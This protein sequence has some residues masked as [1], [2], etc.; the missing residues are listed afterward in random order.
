MGARAIG[1]VAISFGMVTIPVKLYT[2]A[3]SASQIRF[4]QLEQATGARVKQQYISSKTGEIVPR[5]DMV[6]GYEFSK[7]Q[8]V[9]FTPDELKAIEAKSNHAIEINEFVPAKDVDPL[10][11]DKSYYIGPDKGGARAYHLLREAMTQT[12]RVA[13]ASYASRG[14]GYLVMVRPFEHGLIM[15]QLRYSDEVRAFAE[16][17][18]EEVEIRKDELK[19]AIQLIEQVSTKEFKH[20]NY[21]DEVRERVLALIQD[22]VDGKDITMAPEEDSGGKIIDLM[23]ALKK[24]LAEKGK[25]TDKKPA[26]RATRKAAAKTADTK[27]TTRKAANR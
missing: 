7:G 2:T 13:V 14:K 8:Y 22:K 11:F 15:E 16:V 1:S 23:A 24:S 18:I 9:T 6:K 10:I 4:N 25:V 17:S 5:E 20:E 21:R 3:E 19:L 27:T 26:K 12:R